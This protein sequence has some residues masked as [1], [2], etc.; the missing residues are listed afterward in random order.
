MV[1]SNVI[2]KCFVVGT[3]QQVYEFSMEIFD[4]VKVAELMTDKFANFVIQKALEVSSGQLQSFIIGKVNEK[5]AN[6][7]GYQY[8]KHVLNCLEKIKYK[9]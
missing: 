7:R 2:E 6:I 8:G 4:S 5:A 3:S 9:S 1:F